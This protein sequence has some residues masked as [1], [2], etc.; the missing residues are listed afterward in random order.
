MARPANLSNAV[1]GKMKGAVD[2]GE[3]P[4][5][6]KLPTENA[7]C[8]RYSVS[9]PVVRGAMERMRKEGYI[10]TIRGSG[11]FVIKEHVTPASSV[12]TLG[13]FAI[14]GIGDVIQCQETRMAFEGEMAALAAERWTA[15]EMDEL[16]A[17]LEQIHS[18]GLDSVG[19]IDGD[20]RFHTAVVNAAKNDYAAAVYGLMKPQILV[21]MNMSKGLY[22]LLPEFARRH[23]IEEHRAILDAI[24]AR[25]VEGARRE[26]RN[27]IGFFGDQFK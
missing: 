2:S 27:H 12:P 10:K 9:R 5:G 7:L 25:D 13:E 3:F 19:T 11:S 6:L 16:D 18:G 8:E 14:S 20:M 17:A 22:P 21:G 15:S 23:G 26:M 1:Y 4:E 24:R